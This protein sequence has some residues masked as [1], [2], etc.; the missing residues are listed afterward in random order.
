MTKATTPPMMPEELVAAALNE[1]GYL[2]HHKVVDVLRSDDKKAI[3]R[4]SWN[5]EASEVPVSLPNGD[6]TRIDLVLRYGAQGHRPWRVVVEC[7]RSA[8]D[9][10]SWAFFGGTRWSQGSSPRHF[11]VERADLAGTW[12]HQGDPPLN[13]GVET[14]VASRECPIFDYGIEVRIN[15]PGSNQK[16]SATTAIEDAFQQVTLGQA[17]LALRLRAAHALNFRLLPVVV[18]TA[19]LMSAEFSV[20]RVS[21]NHGMIEARDLRLQSRHWLAVNY[22]INDVVCRYSGVSTNRTTDLAADIGARQVRTV[23][24]AQAAH[25]QQFLAWLENAFECDKH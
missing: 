4:H 10:K 21:L 12:N 5:I 24:V 22:R 19:D 14:R 20:D 7:K 13:H 1:Q 18:T 2:L 6:E 17:G 15:R 3:F 23:F 8:R 9:Y 16:S 25:I 11:Y